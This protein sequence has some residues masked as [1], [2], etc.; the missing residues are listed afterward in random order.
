[1]DQRHFLFNCLF[2]T[3]LISSTALFG[4]LE[5][6]AEL[7][8]LNPADEIA[9]A[10]SLSFSGQGGFSIG[11]DVLFGKSQLSPL[12]GAHL[13]MLRYE[14]PLNELDLWQIMLPIGAAYHLLPRTYSFNL[15]ASLAFAPL[16][17]LDEP[18]PSIVS[19]GYLKFAVR[20]GLTFTIDYVYLGFKTYAI[21]DSRFGST[22]DLSWINSFLVGVRF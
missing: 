15:M 6:Y 3:S 9:N 2:V 17:G 4:Q 16:I 19:D 13:Q 10:Q 12:V 1:M 18:E 11:A 5:A 20:G 14:A 8:W 21:P 7:G 22:G